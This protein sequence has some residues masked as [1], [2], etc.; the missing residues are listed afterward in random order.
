MGPFP[1]EQSEIS[2]QA[3]YEKH[4]RACDPQDFQKHVM[5]TVQGKPVGQ[6]QLEMLV[7]GIVVGL[8][9]EPNDV[10]LDLCCGNGAITD[11]IFAKC[12]GGLG[13]D[14]TPYLIEVAK[15]NFERPPD[16]L[17]CLSDACEYAENATHTERFT[18]IL[19]YG[20][21]QCLLESKAAGILLALRRRFANIRC[22]FLGNL[23]DLDQAASY[24]ESKGLDVSPVQ[25]LRRHDTLLGTWRTEEEVTK[26]ASV[27]GWR[28]KISRM[29]PSYYG[30]RY[31]F[32]AIL[33]PA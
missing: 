4:A 31:R 14:F 1:V 9:I 19:C 32:D 20:A 18:K 30:A 25:E 26:L 27:C 16:R 33:I 29:P 22:V 24:F 7:E 2:V 3:L 5:R 11:L 12:R 15:T 21:F 28:A 8:N 6:A 17:Y 23:P 10:L 13:V